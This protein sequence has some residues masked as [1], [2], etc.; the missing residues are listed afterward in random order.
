MVCPFRLRAAT[1]IAFALAA[2]I[3]ACT[4]TP[5]P[6][7]DVQAAEDATPDAATV[8]TNIEASDVAEDKGPVPTGTCPGGALCPC[9]G[10]DQCEGGFCIET[11]DGKKCAKTCTANCPDGY[12][13]NAVSGPGG[14]TV[15]ICVPHWGRAC[16]PCAASD[17]CK[18]L[19]ISP[20]LCIDYGGDLGRY[21]GAPCESHSEC[22]KG[23]FCKSVKSV[24]GTVAKQC[25]REAQSG[26]EGLGLCTCSAQAVA[27]GLKTTC[28]IQ[29]KDK[30]GKV[31]GQCIGAR[32]CTASG[33]TGCTAPDPKP[34]LCNGVDDDCNG[35]TDEGTC[36]DGNPC[37][38]SSCNP[39]LAASGKDGCVQEAVMGPCDADGSTC[40]VGDKCVNAVCMPGPQ[41]LCDDAN[42]CT[43]DGCNLAGDCTHSDDDGATCND[44]NA[45]TVGETCKAS[46][47]NQGTPVVC[48]V[49]N[50]CQ[51]GV[52]DP[53]TGACKFADKPDL[54]PCDDANPCT[55]L[56]VCKGALCL[57]KPKDCNDG[58]PCT[59]E[60]CV[61][62]TGCK[63]Q[64]NK[65]ACSDG[66]ACT[67]GDKCDGGFCKA[68]DIT[69][70]D[71]NAC[72]TDSCDPTKGC[73]NAKL[74][75]ACSD[76]DA[77]TIGDVC[78]DAVC[79]AGQ[80]KV[81]DDKSPCS[82]DSCNPL[83][84]LCSFDGAPF[85]GT[86]CDADGS[87]C[88]VSDKCAGGKCLPG[89]PKNCDDQNV[90]TDD[91]CDAVKGCIKV[92]NTVPC[93]ADDNPCTD[94]DACDQGA[95]KI[96]KPKVC[97]DQ[98]LC[99]ADQ[100]DFATGKCA[101][102]ALTQNG[103]PCDADGSVCTVGDK[104]LNGKCTAGK[105]KACD[106]G[107]PCTDDACEPK[108]DC[109]FTPNTDPCND[110]VPCTV[111]DACVGGQ[112]KKGQP[113]V[114]DDKNGCT[115]D[116]CVPDTGVCSYDSNPM[117]NKACDADKTVCTQNDT[118]KSG[119][120]TP[121]PLLDCDDKNPCTDDA[122]DPVA[123]C[124]HVNNTVACSDGSAC[125]QNDTCG[126]AKCT[127][128]VIKCDDANVCTTDSCDKVAGCQF[129]A[130]QE[131]KLCGTGMVCMGNACKPTVCGDKI[132]HKAVEKCDTTNLDGQT[133]ASVLAP[134]SD[135]TLACS[136][137]CKTFD[138]TGCTVDLSWMETS[139]ECLGWRQS[140][141]HKD[142]GI[143]VRFAV[144]KLN[145]WDKA[146]NYHCPKG[147]HWITTAEAK[148]LFNGQPTN[149]IFTYYSQC[150]W[151]GA[152][153]N[154][155]ERNFFRFND[156]ADTELYKHT[157]GYESDKPD[158]YSK[159][160]RFAGIVCLKD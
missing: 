48:D 148:T 22:D 142:Q 128:T 65:S 45:C 57:G 62:G 25:V 82:I 74:A 75:S 105:A 151:N 100:C 145:V 86:N 150:G 103:L 17:D 101:F 132:V 18:S 117:Q 99:T 126:A 58:N 77:C 156:S 31:I 159:T 108:T 33:L 147:Y 47:C 14:D 56:D 54:T 137:D 92:N 157:S 39:S 121:G 55:D 124:G 38:K 102:V 144:S 154:K 153:W 136:K 104:C 129:S 67:S 85:E 110:N 63:F 115:F 59:D 106:D 30:D 3:A 160:D 28:A 133:C 19:G 84:G 60:A 91:E 140:K 71:G 66:N 122:C 73:V 152:I 149:N 4:E 24:E 130:D 34:E 35:L 11:P 88:T 125:T 146:K 155:L 118:C 36:E 79:I 93:N 21:C 134:G 112:C 40:T 29:H 7:A 27:Q 64:Q 15:S 49:G 123:G 111:G 119:K 50:A 113:K 52:C 41:K 2:C 94:P 20:S 114:C 97:D 116:L 72:T 78:K 5:A 16:N 42:P 95:C 32:T 83:T 53:G 76:G 96:G 90:C 98:N 13:C 43:K 46:K 9:A 26:G 127:G 81:C 69:C 1:V 51:T 89:K 87:V 68:Q 131:G 37:T 141:L 139:D 135:G 107:N 158:L 80:A 6:E 44:G 23:Y 120:C 143:D 70:D 138:T 8:D 61:P 12:L 10:N 109:V